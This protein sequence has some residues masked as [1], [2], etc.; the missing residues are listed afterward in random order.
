MSFA[1][2]TGYLPLSIEAMMDF[3]REN[4]NTK[5]DTTYTAET[6]LG[7]NLYKYFYALIQRLQQNEIKTSEIFLR[8]QEY[9]NITNEKIQR[10][11]T[12]HPG[13]YDYF[14]DR[15]YFISTKPPADENA[16]KAFICVDVEDNHARGTIQIDNYGNLVS[17][18]EDT[19]T[20][21]ETEFTAQGSTVTPGDPTFQAATSNEATA[22][23][24]VSQI[25]SHEHTSEIVDA[26]VVGSI[27][28][29]RAKEG[30]TSGNSI[31]LDYT[32]NDSNEGATISDATLLGGR[33]LESGEQDY[34]VTR[35]EICNLVKNCVIAGIV[36]QGTEIEEITLSNGQSFEFKFNLPNKIPVLL[37]LTITL[38]ENN[39]F[40]ILSPDEVKQKLYD[41]ISAKY[42][43]G[44]NFEPQRYFS[45][46]DVPWAAEVLLE[47]SDDN[48]SNWHDEVYDAEYD[49]VFTFE[50]NDI[51]IV[52]A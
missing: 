26:W 1:S 34:D 31:A 33:A 47:W 40:T 28:Y 49:E 21:D 17:G 29:V 10:P 14:K 12:T 7:T 45:V 24:L 5:F 30:G 9:F 46:I 11:N 48:G 27:V 35:L 36:S 8:L 6:F 32:D 20:I 22:Q 51:T 4:V 18:T 41:N 25:N 13:I 38:S 19:I 52:E 39:E 37:R 42:R 23:S 15:G 3:V 50:L 43:L 2:D 16:G 44:K